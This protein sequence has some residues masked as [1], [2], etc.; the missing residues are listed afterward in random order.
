MRGHDRDVR[1]TVNSTSGGSRLK[2]ENDWHA[3]PTGSPSFVA[4]MV[5]PVANSPNALRI[6]ISSKVTNSAGRVSRISI[7]RTLLAMP[8]F[9]IFANN[10]MNP[11][12]PS[13]STD[14][15]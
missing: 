12:E 15:W 4:T 6:D 7:R 14:P 10:R 9:S 1:I 3:N 5:T 2:E 13:E 11:G 8:I